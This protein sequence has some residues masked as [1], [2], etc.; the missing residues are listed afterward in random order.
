MTDLK[1]PIHRVSAK[2][3]RG[4]INMVDFE[5]AKRFSR[6]PCKVGDIV[7][8]PPQIRLDCGRLIATYW[9]CKHFGFRPV[10]PLN[11]WLK[12]GQKVEIAK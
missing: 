6:I 7:Y 12:A 8:I 5:I 4:K 10:A 3:G 1:K 9:W 11:Y 2:K